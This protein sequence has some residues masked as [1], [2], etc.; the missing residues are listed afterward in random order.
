MPRVGLDAIL[1]KKFEK[2]RILIFLKDATF[3]S[4]EKRVLG[5]CFSI[6]LPWDAAN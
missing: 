3:C 4:I 6:E 2:Y 1:T 5:T